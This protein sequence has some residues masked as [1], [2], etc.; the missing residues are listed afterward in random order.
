[1]YSSSLGLCSSYVAI[2]VMPRGLCSSELSGGFRR[3]VVAALLLVVLPWKEPKASSGVASSSPGINKLGRSLLFLQGCA[4]V[5]PLLAGRG[6]E[7]ERLSGKAHGVALLPPAGRGGEGVR[8]SSSSSCLL[9]AFGG[10]VHGVKQTQPSSVLA[11][12]VVEEQTR[13][14]A[15]PGVEFVKLRTG[16]SK[17]RSRRS[18]PRSREPPCARMSRAPSSMR[19]RSS[20]PATMLDQVVRP[21][22]QRPLCGGAIRRRGPS[23]AVLS[24]AEDPIAFYQSFLGSSL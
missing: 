14:D 9:Q 1:M 10:A 5:L 13:F 18:Y 19:G 16:D 7:E 22:S 11:A 4:A 6:G 2:G 21:R 20:A 15:L 8:W 23:A 12:E 3:Q 17:L 24:L